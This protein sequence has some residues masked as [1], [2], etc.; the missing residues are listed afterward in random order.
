MK[1][2]SPTSTAILKLE[3]E[4]EGESEAPAGALIT[5][6][7]ERRP[8]IGWLELA[9]AIEDWRQTQ[10][11]PGSTTESSTQPTPNQERPL[12]VRFTD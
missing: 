5:P 4:L 6:H 12:D 9:S 3:L 11:R 2:T 7:G 1:E 8:F 10:E